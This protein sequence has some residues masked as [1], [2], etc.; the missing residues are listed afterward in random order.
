MS[1]IILNFC[2]QNKHLFANEVKARQLLPLFEK[3]KLSD[4]EVE[5]NLATAAIRKNYTGSLDNRI[6]QWY[7]HMTSPGAGAQY[8]RLLVQEQVG[9]SR[10]STYNLPPGSFTYGDKNVK[11]P[12]NAGEG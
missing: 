7:S 4:T 2:S 3:L 1:E 8:N 9:K 12:E 10:T 5:A 6:L 11:D